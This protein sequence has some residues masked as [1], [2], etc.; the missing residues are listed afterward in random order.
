MKDDPHLHELREK[1]SFL[2][3][4]L[5]PLEH[6]RLVSGESAANMARA[7]FLRREIAELDEIIAREEGR[8]G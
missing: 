5:E 3:D 7:H 8:G 1:R 4:F 6:G 2:C